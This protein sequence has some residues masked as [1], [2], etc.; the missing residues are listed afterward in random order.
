[1][2][3]EISSSVTFSFFDSVKSDV[4]FLLVIDVTTNLSRSILNVSARMVLSSF[5]IFRS[6]SPTI[7]LFPA[8]IV[9]EPIYALL[10]VDSIPMM[11]YPLLNWTGFRNSHDFLKEIALPDVVKIDLNSSST[12]LKSFVVIW[13]STVRL[14][15]IFKLPYMTCIS[16]VFVSAIVLISHWIMLY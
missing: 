3:C 13:E 15:L 2:F 11:V 7:N 9:G 14:P 10:Y 4:Y 1:M 12:N 16:D 5:V 8:Y 6:E